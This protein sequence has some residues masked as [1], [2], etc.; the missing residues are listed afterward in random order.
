M[1]TIVNS[2]EMQASN[3]EMLSMI[4]KLQE[5][6]DKLQQDFEDD[7]LSADDIE[8]L[9]KAEEE[10]KNGETISLEDLEKELGM[11]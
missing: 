9:K 3:Q 8:A 11:N 6:V 1:E 2:M 7:Q 5:R 4:L 10:Y